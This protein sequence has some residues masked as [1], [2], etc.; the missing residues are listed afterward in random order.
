MIIKTNSD[1]ETE[2]V[3]YT[4]AKALDEKGIKD[5]YVALRG[6][7]GVGKTVFTRGFGSYFGIEGIKSPT[8]T[9][10]NEHHGAASLFHFD[11]YRIS[12]DDDL[13]SIGYDDYLDRVGYKLVEWSENTEEIPLDAIYVTISRDSSDDEARIIEISDFI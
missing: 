2:K 9:V 6:E 5:A 7:M 12:D 8:Y 3:G 1:K 13:T 11:L 10:V 4:L